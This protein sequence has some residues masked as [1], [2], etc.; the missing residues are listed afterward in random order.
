LNIRFNQ[1]F[2]NKWM[3][4]LNHY[5]VWKIRHFSNKHWESVI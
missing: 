2:D 1:Q 5:F 4:D 3:I